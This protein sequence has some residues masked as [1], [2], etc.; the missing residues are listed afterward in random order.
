MANGRC[1]RQKQ[2]KKG[3]KAG[4]WEGDRKICPD[5]IKAPHSTTPD[6]HKVAG[7]EVGW[8]GTG[9]GSLP[10]AGSEVQK[11]HHLPTP[12]SS[13]CSW[14]AL[15]PFGRKKNTLALFFPLSLCTETSFILDPNPLPLLPISTGKVTVPPRPCNLEGYEIV[16][17]V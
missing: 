1:S 16:T 13:S 11:W 9:L 2:G 3:G 6:P 12:P 17:I 8:G 15:S 5:R 7:E 14:D 4:R 10:E